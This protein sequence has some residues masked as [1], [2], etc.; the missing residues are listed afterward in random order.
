MTLRAPIEYVGELVRVVDHDGIDDAL[1]PHGTY[2]KY[3]QDQCRCEPCLNSA[4]L[5]EVVCISHA[6]NRSVRQAIAR[7]DRS[8]S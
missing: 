2:V 8:G 4:M 7:A 6:S 3:V 1:R 5:G